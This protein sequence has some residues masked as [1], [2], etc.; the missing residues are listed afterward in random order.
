MLTFAGELQSQQIYPQKDIPDVTVTI[1]T[2]TFNKSK[3]IA[4]MKCIE[5]G[6]VMRQTINTPSKYTGERNFD[7]E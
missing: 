6:H 4:L 7:V 2:R 3:I 5:D 1:E